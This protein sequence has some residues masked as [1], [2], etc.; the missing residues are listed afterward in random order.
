MTHLPCRSWCRCCII[1]RGREQD[2]RRTMEE[3]RQVSEFHLDHM[4]MG[5]EKEGK[6]LAFLVA[7]ERER[8]AVL[9]T[10]VPRKTTGDWLCR[11]LMA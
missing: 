10:V 7:R 8:R 4:F 9:N 3:E 5:D 2:C 1:E 11:R 6:T